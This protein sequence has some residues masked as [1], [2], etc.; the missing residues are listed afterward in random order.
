MSDSRRQVEKILENEPVIRK[1]LQWGIINSRALARFI[2]LR[3]KLDASPEAILGIIRRFPVKEGEGKESS[4]VLG[5]CELAMRDKVAGLVLENGSETMKRIS[6]FAASIKST[7]GENL[8]IV[9]GLRWITVIA[10][11]NALAQFRESFSSKEVFRYDRDLVEISIL[12]T[13]AS[14]D[15]KGVF[16]RITGELFLNDVNLLSIDT[17]YLEMIILMKEESAAKAIATLQNLISDDSSLD[18]S[19]SIVNNNFRTHRSRVSAQS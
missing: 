7:R 19:S 17:S 1:G 11:Q 15:T 6:E 8:R 13:P 10:N 18:P 3:D 5:N 12:L 16:A 4:R 14:T 2:Q 9:V